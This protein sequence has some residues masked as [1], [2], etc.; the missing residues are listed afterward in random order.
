MRK[1]YKTNSALRRFIMTIVFLAVTAIVTSA[2]GQQ[3]RLAVT[4]S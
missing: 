3:A 1:A 4:A 2:C